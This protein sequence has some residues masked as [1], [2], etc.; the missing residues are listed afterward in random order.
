MVD[1]SYCTYEDGWLRTRGLH[2]HGF[3]MLLWD[4]LMQTGHEEE[5]LEYCGWLYMEHGMP[6]YEV[7]VDIR[8]QPMFP[9]GSPWSTWV[10]RNN[11]D[12]AM[13]KAA[14]V[15][16]TALCS[17][18]LPDTVDTSISLYL[19]QGRSNLEWMTCIYEACN[20][21]Q[22]HYHA[23]WAYMV[24]YAQHLFQP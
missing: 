17:Q 7:N 16:L 5:V 11:M 2:H 19:I 23:G 9:N 24:R 18:R 4:A 22:D 20:V 14:H 13:D 8:S 12:D 1:Y 21:F 3:P 6:Y 10:I 15:A